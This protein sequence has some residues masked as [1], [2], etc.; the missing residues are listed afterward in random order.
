[1]AKEGLG[2]AAG[3][4]GPSLVCTCRKSQPAL[5]VTVL[6]PHDR[7][8]QR[9]RHLPWCRGEAA[10]PALPGPRKGQTA[11][12]P[13]HCCSQG[14]VLGG[15]PAEERWAG[16]W[17]L[18]SCLTC[19][20]APGLPPALD[21][22]HPAPRFKARCYDE[23]PSASPDPHRA[24]RAG[25]TFAHF[26]DE[27]QSSGHHGDHRLGWTGTLAACGP[28]ESGC[29]HRCPPL[30]TVGVKVVRCEGETHSCKLPRSSYC[31]YYL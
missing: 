3:P 5:A 24:P 29:C 2:R 20:W 18:R 26:P 31:Y 19:C 9:D 7:R 10:G 30:R 27:I 17:G 28:T 22:P 6:I 13:P 4:W 1:M 14:R 21:P 23:C 12:S 15:L 11:L 8:D 25:G 16:A